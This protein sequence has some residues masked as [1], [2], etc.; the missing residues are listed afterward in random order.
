M[1]VM[2]GLLVVL[3]PE[4][5]GQPVLETRCHEQ[6][7]HLRRPG[8]SPVVRLWGFQMRGSSYQFLMV[9]NETPWPN[10]GQSQV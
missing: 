9:T 7:L 10:K 4:D 3:K 1:W 8:A 5:M 6:K 2:M